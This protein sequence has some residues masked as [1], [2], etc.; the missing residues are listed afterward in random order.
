MGACLLILGRAGAAQPS[1][2]GLGPTRDRLAQ[3]QTCLGSGNDA[4]SKLRQG[5]LNG[6]G[7]SQWKQPYPTLFGPSIPPPPQEYLDSLDADLRACD[8]AKK[9]HDQAVRQAILDEV[10]KDIAVKA[11]DCQKFGMGRLI[12]VK[13]STI[14]GQTPE[15][16]WVVFWKWMPAGPLQTVE[17]SMPGVTSPATRQFPPGTYAFRAEKR[18]SSTELRSTETRTIIVGGAQSVDCPLMIE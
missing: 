4:L 11:E 15:N 16:G 7:A 17:T 12:Q 6:W 2:S 13:V 14:R 3:L 8:L 10:A 9:E 1:Q 18:I 5:L